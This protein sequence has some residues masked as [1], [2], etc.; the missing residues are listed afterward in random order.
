MKKEGIFLIAVKHPYYGRM[1]YN[2]AASVK[3][4]DPTFPVT[5]AWG[6]YALNHLTHSQLAVFDDLMEVPDGGLVNKLKVAELTPYQKTLFCDVDAVWLPARSPKVLIEQMGE[7]EFC[8]ITEGWTG[9]KKGVESKEHAYPL[10][11]GLEQIRKA[12]KLKAS[13]LYQCRSEVMYMKKTKRVTEMMSRAVDI[14]TNPAIEV[15]GFAGELPDEFALNIAL[16]EKGFDIVPELWKPSYWSPFHGLNIPPVAKLMQEYFM[17][18][19][20]GNNVDAGTMKLYNDICKAACRKIGQQ[21][22]FP[23][24]QKRNYLTERRLL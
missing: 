20:G 3:A 10:W 19:A 6:G 21:Y 22:L 13:K 15:R 23:L 18:S 9:L 24:M 11:A 8:A 12:Y 7:S 2:F 14:Y 5:V 16:A 4:A 1:A 17:L